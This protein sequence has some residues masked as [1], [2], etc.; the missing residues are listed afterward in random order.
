MVEM[1]NKET[2]KEIKRILLLSSLVITLIS[3]YLALIYTPTVKK[4]DGWVAPLAQKI[5]YFH[6]PSAWVAYLA[7]GVVFVCSILYLKTN[8]RKWDI[9]AYSSAEIGVVFCTLAIITGPIWARAE[10]G[11]YW[12]WED[13]KLFMTLVLWLIFLAYIA[14]R[15]EGGATEH[16][17]RL[18]AVF[19]IIGFVCVPLSFAANRIWV[20]T[21]PTVIATSRG[22]VQAPMMMALMVAV[23]AFT[24]LY[25]Y[26]LMERIDLEKLSIRIEELKEEIGGD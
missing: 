5:F 15:A 21:H 11:V 17:A 1:I 4:A 6:V 10:W 14:L 24:L 16:S 2:L 13:L 7:F 26:I 22:S 20:Q 8:S 3:I 12:Q 18:G 25:F 9:I 19:G 23:I